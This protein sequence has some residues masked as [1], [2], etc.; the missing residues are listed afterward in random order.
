MYIAT[1][2]TMK[3][4]SDSGGEHVDPRQEEVLAATDPQAQGRY[5]ARITITAVSLD[6]SKG[7]F[8][9][10]RRNSTDDDDVESAIVSVPV[11]NSDQFDFCFEL[12]QD[13]FLSVTPY[14]DMIGTVMA[15]INF[16]RV[17]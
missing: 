17:G 11:D 5:S 12:E 2:R 14:T 16:Q 10:H 1:A 15:A 13:E 6:D 7:V 8:V 3:L 9:V 4:A